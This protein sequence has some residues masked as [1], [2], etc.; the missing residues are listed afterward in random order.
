MMEFK[1]VFRSLIPISTRIRLE[2]QFSIAISRI[3]GI[4][5]EFD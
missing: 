2:S 1:T 4:Q 5:N 3:I